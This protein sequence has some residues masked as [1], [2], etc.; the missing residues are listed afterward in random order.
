MQ[1][2]EVLIGEIVEVPKDNPG[3]YRVRIQSVSG[4]ATIKGRYAPPMR[5]MGAVLELGQRVIGVMGSDENYYIIATIPSIFKAGDKK[6]KSTVFG[7]DSIEP[8]DHIIGSP[9]TG[10]SIIFGL[11]GIINTS[12][13]LSPED[14]GVQQILLPGQDILRNLCRRFEIESAAG[15][16]DCY[17]DDLTGRTA[18]ALW[19]RPFRLP[20]FDGKNIRLHMGWHDDLPDAMFS[21]T[22]YP[23][24]TDVKDKAASLNVQQII[25]ST[26]TESELDEYGGQ[27]KLQR[28]ERKDW[29]TRFY[30][31]YLGTTVLESAPIFV[32][33]PVK[34]VTPTIKVESDSLLG[35]IKTFCTGQVSTEALA[36]AIKLATSYSLTAADID[37][38]AAIIHAIA[39]GQIVLQSPYVKV[40]AAQT[41]IGPDALKGMMR[42]L[43]KEEL[44][45]YVEQLVVQ[46]SNIHSHPVSGASTGPPYQQISPPSTAIPKDVA[47][48]KTLKAV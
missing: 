36:M 14:E 47:L 16:I 19:A 27:K 40:N 15:D 41:T 37:M 2:K 5:G 31:T 11:D 20:G 28:D 34:T 26:I 33:N 39:T 6:L 44:Y 22:I 18:M 45:D 23:V 48:T 46:H 38:K 9:E 4:G 42:K 25:N 1:Q 3:I 32:P 43:C 30:M 7:S 10:S 8:G 29:Q 13:T 12:A 24:G 35:T 17:H 21:V